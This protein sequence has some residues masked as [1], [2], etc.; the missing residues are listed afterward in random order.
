MLM[1]MSP[2]AEPTRFLKIKEF[3]LCRMARLSKRSAMLSL[4]TWTACPHRQS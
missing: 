3:F 2:T 1:W 4:T